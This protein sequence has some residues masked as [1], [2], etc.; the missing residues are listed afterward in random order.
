MTNMT[1]AFSNGVVEKVKTSPSI[2]NRAKEIRRLQRA[3]DRSKRASNPDN[4]NAD[5]TIKKGVR[6]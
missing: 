3:M 4:F 1:L 5:G 6:T 2:E